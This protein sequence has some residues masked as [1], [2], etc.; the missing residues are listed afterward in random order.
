M[1]KIVLINKNGDINENSY[2]NLQIED[3]YKKCNYRKNDDFILLNT[4]KFKGNKKSFKICIYGKEKG[5]ANMENKYDLPPPVDSKLFFGTLALVKI[6]DDNLE[7]L[8]LDEWGKLYEKMFGGFEDLENTFEEDENEIDELKNVPA[9]DKTK[10]GYL[11][12][13]FVVDD[14]TSTSNDSKVDSETDTIESDYSETDEDEDED[15]DISEQEYILSDD[16]F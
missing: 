5:K 11:K 16:E 7:D 13:G 12:D 4:W 6:I 9:E 2:K 14:K 1:T 8:A 10:T 15:E 3:L